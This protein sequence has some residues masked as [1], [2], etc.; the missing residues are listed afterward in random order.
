MNLLEQIIADKRQEVAQRLSKIDAAS[1]HKQPADK[2][3]PLNF[4]SYLAGRQLSIIAEVKKASPSKGLIRPDFD[5][6]AI[7]DTYESAGADCISVLTEEKYFQGSPQFL[8]QIRKRVK[9]QAQ[10]AVH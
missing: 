5:P 8:R 9:C 2:R 6:V 4:K 7:A 1:L 3:I 10:V